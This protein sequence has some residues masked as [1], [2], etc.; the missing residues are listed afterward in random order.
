MPDALRIGLLGPLQVRDQAGRAIHVGGRQLRVLLILLALDA[1]RVVPSGSLAD[2]IWPGDLPANPGNALQTLVSR[3]RA[4]L[5]RSGLDDVIESHPAGYRLVVPPDAVDAV[6][7]EALAV[8]GRGALA[9]G[10]AQQAARVLRTAL[11]SWRGQPLADAAGCDFADVAAARLSELH[12]S[13]LADRIEADLALGEGASLV[14]ELRALS[15][16]DPLAERPRALLMRALYAAGRQAEALGVYQEARELLAGRLGVGPSAQLEQVY[17]RILRGEEGPAAVSKDAA[18]PADLSL[19]S[20]RTGVPAPGTP[21]APRVPNVPTSFVG[22][23]AE[24]AQV[25]KS[26]AWARLVTLTG[27][28][29]VGKTRLAAEVS[30]RLAEGAWFVELAPVTDP[31]EVAYA[32]LDTLGVREAVIARRAGEPG[33]GPL[34]RLAAVL[35]DRDDVMILDNCEHVIEA[36]AALAGRVLAACPRVRIVAT[37]RQPLRI[38]GEILCPVPPLRVPPPAAP[39]TGAGRSYESYASVR[40]LRDRAVAVR[41]DFELDARNAAAVARICRALD[42]MPLAIEL[43]AVWLRTLTPAQLAG[44]LDDRFALFTGGSRAALPR[45]RTLRAVV[46]W[47]WDLLAPAEQVLARRL[48]VFPAGATLAMAEQVCADQWLPSAQVLPALSG[49]VDKSIIAAGP[50]YRMLETVRAYGLERLAEAGEHDRV[51]DAFAA[52]Y[53]DLAETTDPRLRAAGQGYWLGELAAEQDNLHA[54]LRWAITRRDAEVA[55]RFVRALGWYWVL[56][57][58]PGEPQTLARDVLG[59]EPREH[60][61]RIAEA[62][63]VCAMTASGPSWEID[64]VRPVLDAAVADFVELTHG[65]VPSNPVAA[66]GEPMLAIADRDPERAFAV[67]DRYMISPDPWLRAA[68]P[69]MRSS[70]GRLLGHID[71]AESDCRQSLEGFRALGESWGAASV[72]IQM[73]DFSQLRADY[74]TAIAALEEA[75]SFGRELGAWGDLS[76]IDGMLAQVRLKQG[77]LERARADLEQA[78]HA[79]FERGT[80]LSDA[81]AWLALVRAELHWR[82]GDMAAAAGNC[83]KVLA[84]LDQK[85]SPWWDGMRAQL[86][87]RLALVVLREGHETRCRELLAAALGTAAGWVERPALGAVIDAIA[88]FVLGADGSAGPTERAA[89]AATLLGFGHTVRGAFDEGSLDAPGARD[90]ARGVLGHA[91]FEGAYQRGRELGRDDALALASGAVAGLRPA[92]VDP[93]RERGEYDEDAQR[94]EHGMNHRG[95]GRA[96]G[97]Q[98]AYGVGQAGH[99][100]DLHEGLQPAGHGIGRHE[101]VAAEHQREEREEPEDL[102]SLRRLHQQADKGG[103]PA[104]GQGEHEQQQAAGRGGG[105]IGGDPEPEDRTEAE[106]DRD[107]DGVADHVAEDGA[108]ERRPAGDRQAAEPVEDPAG[109][110]L[111]QHQPGAQGGEHHGHHEQARQLVLQVRVRAAMGDGPAEH[112]GEQHQEHDR[113]QAEPDHVLHVGPDLQHAAPGER[114]GVPQPDQRPDPAGWRRNGRSRAGWCRDRGHRLL[115]SISRAPDSSSARCPVRAKNT[116][117]RLAL[118]S[119]NSASSMPLS[120]SSRTTRGSSALSVTAA[121]TAPARASVATSA[122]ATASSS[123]AASA[124]RPGSDGATMS[125]WPPVLVLSSSGVPVAITSPRSMTT[126]SWASWSASSRYWVVSRTVTPSATRPRIMAHTSVRLRGSSP[127]V[128]SSR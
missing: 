79:Q 76:Y 20:E 9:R 99:R 14:G 52:H 100:V 120:S 80:H 92:P 32:V 33:A 122:P 98:A 91:E 88:V 83:A 22:R 63:I 119:V 13:V 75:R 11:A 54:A 30:G 90:A 96:A 78:E 113:L 74:A 28:G 42:G 109:D 46:D 102:D 67:F 41:P 116:S 2:Q 6:A 107:R 117:S 51:R 35:A 15:S 97:E 3:L 72:L 37:S 45:H 12:S 34:D 64:T 95:G 48:A 106:G 10:D 118:R 44:R 73:A 47:S 81:G 56:R 69:L 93:D 7:F 18:R 58:Q 36:A 84:W 50:R 57:G 110:V 61:V 25:L 111:V 82:E 39:P 55:L 128:G 26:L 121:D 112:V 104:H 77:D 103:D 68:V 86:Q 27:P 127:V 62:R 94:P 123:A 85:Q 43:A 17:L 105:R 108:A 31:A 71:W 125:T 101:Q 8:Q 89:L 1:G 124:R 60:S 23:D 40:L 70:F 53:L 66:M 4:E 21:G 24:V 114:E 126:M 65:E 5:R 49:L 29:G 87:A 19:D 59:L 115:S 38:D 16:A